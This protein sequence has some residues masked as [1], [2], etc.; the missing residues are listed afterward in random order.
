MFPRLSIQS[1]M[2]LAVASVCVSLY[3]SIRCS[4]SLTGA[5]INP[6]V[7][8]AN[9]AVNAISGRQNNF[10]YLPQYFFG[11]ILGGVIG[12]VVCKVMVMPNVPNFYGDLLT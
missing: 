6:A 1:D 11:S 4:E 9:I 2:V 10:S 7:A 5:G 3:F 12:G 8:L